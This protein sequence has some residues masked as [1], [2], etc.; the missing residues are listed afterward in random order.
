MKLPTLKKLWT[1]YA[2]ACRV[3]PGGIQWDETEGAFYAGAFAMLANQHHY[4]DGDEAVLVAWLQ[5]LTEEAQAFSQRR[6]ATLMQRA[7]GRHG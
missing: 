4:A 2:M 7:G 1:D 5:R 6:V 3:P